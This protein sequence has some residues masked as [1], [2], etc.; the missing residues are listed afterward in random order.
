MNP[1]PLQVFVRPVSE[2]NGRQVFEG[3]QGGR[4][5][6]ELHLVPFVSAARTGI[7]GLRL[8]EHPIDKDEE[9][10]DRQE[11]DNHF[12]ALIL[13]R[14]RRRFTRIQNQSKPLPL[15]KNV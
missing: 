4:G 10:D 14:R 12:H 8:R 7:K 15:P 9:R 13:P 11:R 3:W 5:A 1:L 2:V 6:W